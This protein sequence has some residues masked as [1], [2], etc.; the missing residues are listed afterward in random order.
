[1]QKKYTEYTEEEWENIKK[2]YVNN[3][4]SY[5][6]I[7]QKYNTC[8]K[9]CSKYLNGLKRVIFE[10]N[11]VYGKLTFIEE[12]NYRNEKNNKIRKGKFRCECGNETIVNIIAVK[13]NSIISCGCWRNR[14]NGET[15]SNEQS[16][17][18]KTYTSWVAM[19]RR[20][21]Y[22]K[23]INYHNYGGR[24]IIV[25]ERW[26]DKDHGFNNF[27]EDMGERP[28][29]MTLDRIDPDGNY[30]PSNCRWAPIDVQNSN[31]RKHKKN[32]E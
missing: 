28:E 25:C 6:E 16:T 2:D 4:L 26:L 24:G 20:C 1:M 21:D 14:S 31:M 7:C 11:K 12:I 13:N 32:L 17:Y 15:I 5:K 27:K 30:E 9:K 18:S 23:H 29:G 22:P 19:K 3:N 8:V 10:I